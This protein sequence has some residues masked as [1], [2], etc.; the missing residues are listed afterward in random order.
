MVVKYIAQHSETGGIN[1]IVKLNGNWY[2]KRLTF[3]EQIRAYL[4][5]EA[6]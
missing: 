2:P 5:T 3:I 4:L 1:D 6:T